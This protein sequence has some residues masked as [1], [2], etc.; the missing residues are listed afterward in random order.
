M[1]IKI[2]G[3][4]ETVNE[5][6]SLI[7]LLEEKKLNLNAIVVEYNL[8]IV[9]NEEWSSIALKENDSIEVLRFVGGGW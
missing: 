8:E 9:K 4:E 6:I 2:N 5:K 1:N 7:E 3:K